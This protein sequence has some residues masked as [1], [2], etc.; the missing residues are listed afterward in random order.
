MPEELSFIAITACLR[1][2][3]VIVVSSCVSPIT[4]PFVVGQDV[5]TLLTA[6]HRDKQ[7][8][9]RTTDV[10]PLS[11]AC[12][13]QVEPVPSRISISGSVIAAN[14]CHEPHHNCRGQPG[15]YAVNS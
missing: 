15:G 7:I 5:K 13:G 14:R 11:Q 3:G 6:R 2:P 10:H 12:I 9:A 1:G 8:S 4:A